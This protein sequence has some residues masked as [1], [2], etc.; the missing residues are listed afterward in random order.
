MNI[1]IAE[2]YGLD[3][4]ICELC[5]YL[6]DISAVISHSDMMDYAI[7]NG[8]HIDESERQFPMLLHQRIARVIA[9]E[10]FGV[11]D[12]RILS[13]VEHHTTLK[14]NPSDYDLA[15]FI[16]DKLAWDG[17]GEAPFYSVVNNAL[18]HSLEAACLAYQDYIVAH[19]IIL[20]PHKW[21]KESVHW[22]RGV[23]GIGKIETERLILRQ[24]NI[25]DA[26]AMFRNWAN[27]PEAVRFMPYDVCATVEDTVNHIIQWMRYFEETAPNSALFAIEL[28]NNGEVIG[29][30]DFTETDKEARSAEVG[31]QFGKAWW[32][33]GYATEALRAIIQ[34]CFETVK[35]NRLWASYDPRNPASGRVLEKAKM[36]YEGT[37]RQCKIRR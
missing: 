32:G 19:K 1:K 33:Q 14:A 28:K 13:A 8:W 27:D 3:K 22:L 35:L 15:V 5:G 12:E 36:Q 10:D 24:F 34:H 17:D 29:T 37:L 21:F 2:Q 9:Q 30:I 31:Y 18:K 4:D 6:H 7:K 20:H 26:E 16:A 23:I 11:T 25:T